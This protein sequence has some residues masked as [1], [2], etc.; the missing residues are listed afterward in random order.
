MI[1]IVGCLV[2]LAALAI[3]A[4]GCGGGCSYCTTVSAC[5]VPTGM[6]YSLVYPVP[7]STGNSTSLSEV[8]VATSGTLPPTWMTGNG[9]DVELNYTATGSYPGTAFGSDFATVSVNA[10]PTPNASPS[11]ANP[12]YFVSTFSYASNANTP[13]PPG[14][15]ITATLNN[16]NS[17]CYP[18]VTIGKFS[19]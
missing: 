11:F 1:R 18:G 6:Q 19:T 4:V 8:V 16:L 9:W 3:V 2:A 17:S 13:L 10:I 5:T 7:S 15:L 12:S 14:T